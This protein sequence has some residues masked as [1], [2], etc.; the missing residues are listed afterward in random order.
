MIVGTC[1]LCRR[2]C[3]TYDVLD[4]RWVHACC[5]REIEAWGLARCMACDIAESER[6]RAESHW[7][8]S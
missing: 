8:A 3:W 7:Q 1:E 5:V 6:R 4:E 2:V